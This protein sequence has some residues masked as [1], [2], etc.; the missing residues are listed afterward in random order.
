MRGSMSIP[1]ILS[2]TEKEYG[3]LHWHPHHDPVSELI[4]T[5]LSQ[6]TSDVNSK[7]ASEE[8]LSTFSI[9]E[10]V[11]TASVD[12]IASTIRTG[13]L[14]QVKAKRIKMILNQLLEQ[15]GSIDLGFLTSL[16]LDEAKVWLKK[17]PGVG[18][19]TAA[20][21]LLFSL[22]K[23][24]LPVDTHVHRV[25]QRLGLIDSGVSPARAHDILEAIVPPED[26]YQFHLHM[27]E[28]GRRICKAQYPLCHRCSL[29]GGCP[30]NNEQSS[31]QEAR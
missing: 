11:A 21:V 18:P 5:I 14:A 22:G 4:L 9:W 17:F 2:L 12:E 13:G 28:H 7:R 1:E 19:K 8:L 10:A 16:P 24:A 30:S 26:I 20:C 15:Q 23:P 27:V 3:P 31:S 25:A 6:N 29:A